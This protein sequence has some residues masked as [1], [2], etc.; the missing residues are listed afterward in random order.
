MLTNFVEFILILQ[1]GRVLAYRDA[2]TSLFFAIFTNNSTN[3]FV[4]IVTP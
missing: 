3:Y 1:A 2:D 4:K